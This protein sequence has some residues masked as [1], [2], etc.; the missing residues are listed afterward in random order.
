MI[1][2]IRNG[3]G[4][5]NTNKSGLAFE[6]LTN[7]PDHIRRDLSN[8]YELRSYSIK[9]ENRVRNSKDYSYAVFD[10]KKNK[11]IGVITR[12]F[13]FYNVL[14]QL[15]H[16]VN[17]HHKYWKPDDAFFNINK[18]TLFIVEKKYQNQPGSV[19]EKLFGL[20][21]KRVI[22]QDLFNRQMDEPVIPVE[23]IAMFNSSWWLKG[24]TLDENGQIIKTASVDYH[25][26]FDSLRNNGVKIMFDHY[27]DWFLGL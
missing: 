2:T 16:I 11:Q 3:K 26:Y 15:Y 14:N 22:Y 7:L 10:K 6:Q 19:D 4:G 23:F 5:A 20:N 13:Q 1:E 12:Q 17:N 21:A 27:E 8:K 25:D 9:K 24:Q 18:H